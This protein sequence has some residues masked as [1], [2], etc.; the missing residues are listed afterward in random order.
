L[1]AFSICLAEPS[2]DYKDLVQQ[3]RALLQEE[4]PIEAKAKADAA[5]RLEPKRYE[6]YAMLALIAVK[7]GDLAAAKEALAK[8]LQLAPVEKRPSLEALQKKLI[9]PDLQTITPPARESSRPKPPELT[10][11][12]RRKLETIML[13]VEE[14]DKTTSPN[15]RQRLLSELL[16][17]SEPFVRENPSVSSVWLLR[18]AAAIEVNQAHAGWEAGKQLKVL[19][20]ADGGD[21]RARRVMAMLDRKGWLVANDPEI[22]Q[23]DQAESERL[24]REAEVKKQQEEQARRQAEA[25][26]RAQLRAEQEQVDAKRVRDEGLA[27]A[28]KNI[29][30]RWRMA[31]AFPVDK[32]KFSGTLVITNDFSGKVVVDAA[33]E[34]SIKYVGW[35]RYRVDIHASVKPSLRRLVEG[36]NGIWQTHLAVGTPKDSIDLIEFELPGTALVIEPGNVPEA[37]TRTFSRIHFGPPFNPENEAYGNDELNEPRLRQFSICFLDSHGMRTCHS[38]KLERIN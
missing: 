22:A 7:Q 37:R 18:A 34:Y 21:P 24:R 1:L 30:G 9:E 3:A 8:A 35:D 38:F 26:R 19:G 6:P 15:D 12:P 29:T 4:K 5:V 27:A 10:G 33:C 31:A 25:D 16:E 32:D 11:E 20:V 23:R 28:I 14:A 17:K 2:A 13:I 36:E